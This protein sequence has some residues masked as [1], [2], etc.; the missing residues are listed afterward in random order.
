MDP[1]GLRTQRRKSRSDWIRAVTGREEK[2]VPR[3]ED[4]GVQVN[5]GGVALVARRL[6]E[7][8]AV[9]GDLSVALLGQDPHALP[10]PLFGA[11][12]LGEDDP[13]VDEPERLTG[14]VR[15]G[16]EV[17]REIPLDTRGMSADA[18][19]HPGDDRHGQAGRAPEEEERPAP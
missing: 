8:H 18:L 16:R 9:V 19:D 15:V 2:A 6:F 14:E 11:R 7:V 4:H 10:T 13:G 5:L 3:R 17:P 12:K 1:S